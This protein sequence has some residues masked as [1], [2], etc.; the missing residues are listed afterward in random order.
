MNRSGLL[1]LTALAA[2]VAVLLAALGGAWLLQHRIDQRIDRVGSAFP[3]DSGRPSGGDDEELTVLLLGQDWYPDSEEHGRSDAVMLVQVPSDRSSVSV[4]SIPRDSWVSVPGHGEGKINSALVLGG[5]ALAVETVENLTEI[6]VDHVMMVDGSGFPALVDTLG[7]VTVEIP[8]TVHDDARGITW[9]AGEHQLDGEGA[10]DYVGQRY[11]LPN[12]DLDRV[13]RHQNFLRILLS[14]LV[15][16][17]TLT[18]PRATYELVRSVA[19]TVVVDDQWGIGAMRDLALSLRHIEASDIAFAT[20]PVAGLDEVDGQ[21]VVRLE[22]DEG[23]RLWGA[24]RRGDGASW[25]RSHGDG[26][27]GPVA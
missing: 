14:D 15:G 11:G 7:G 12:G 19:E 24:M 8:E 23:A 1:A 10:L 25:I 16:S 20:A 5:P 4:V 21:S 6:R 17:A 26:L 9:A 22:P 13:R 27:T 18:E 2:L 3:V